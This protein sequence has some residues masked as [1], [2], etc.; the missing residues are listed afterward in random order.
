MPKINYVKRAEIARKAGLYRGP[1]KKLTLANKQLLS[2]LFNRYPAIA[3]HKVNNYKSVA[4]PKAELAEFSKRGFKTF[5]GR[6]IVNNPNTT[7]LIYSNKYKA[8]TAI[9][10]TENSTIRNIYTLDLD[11]DR[12]MATSKSNDT[13]IAMSNG[14][15]GSVGKIL[16]NEDAEKYAE[17]YNDRLTKNPDANFKPPVIVESIRRPKSIAR[18][19]T[20]RVPTNWRV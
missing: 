16:S 2:T 18:K 15:Q 20:R 3:N 4:V 10:D 6:V 11:L 9:A 12:F 1:A 5:K 7:R 19:V 14:G 13:Y 17:N 8:I